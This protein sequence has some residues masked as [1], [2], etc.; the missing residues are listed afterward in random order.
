MKTPTE[1]KSSFQEFF[2]SESSSGILLIVVTILALIV[3]S[4]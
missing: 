4:F 1:P 3:A 2:E